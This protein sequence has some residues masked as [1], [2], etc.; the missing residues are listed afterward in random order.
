MKRFIKRLYMKFIITHLRAHYPY[1][2][3]H[4]S[5]H[6]VNTWKWTDDVEQILF[7]RKNNE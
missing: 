3:V 2:I 7:K 1:A 4:D 5:Q 6:R